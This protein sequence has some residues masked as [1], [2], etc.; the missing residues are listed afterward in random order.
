MNNCLTN[1]ARFLLLIGVIP[2][3]AA[4]RAKPSWWKNAVIY[5]VYP[6]SFQDSDGDGV[7]DLKGISSRLDYLEGLGVDAI[8]IA[9]FFSSPQVDFGYD[10]SN[11]TAVDP[12]YGS[13]ADFDALVLAARARHIR[14][15]L[16]LVLNHTSD[17]HPRFKASRSSRADSKRDWYVWKDGR[18]A[19]PPSNWPDGKGSA[20]TRDAAT[21]QYY[22]HAYAVEQPDL[23]WRSEAMR[24][25]M[26][27]VMRFWMRRGVAGFRLD[28]VPHLIEDARLR[29]EPPERD[30]NG[31]ISRDA[32]GAIRYGYTRYAFLPESHEALKNVR[33]V[34]DAFPGR[35]LL[36]EAYVNNVG[37]LRPYYG[38]GDEIQLPMAMHF[39]FND[40]GNID[41]FRKSIAGLETL[42]VG[43]EPLIVFGNHD[44]P[45]WDRF[46]KDSR[47]AFVIATMLL[48]TRGTATLYQ[49]DEIGMT[50][51][52]PQRREDVRDPVGVGGWP[53]NKGRDGSRTPMQWS[54]AIGG[55][56][57]TGKPWLPVS[58]NLAVH[59]VE[60]LTR[61]GG[62][63]L[64][65]H[66]RLIALRRTNAAL[67]NG[68][69]TIVDAANPAILAWTRHV[70]G[71]A[72]VIVATNFTDSSATLHLAPG[73]VGKARTLMSTAPTGPTIDIKHLDLAPFGVF[74]GEID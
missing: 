32:S 14:V 27:D 35:V 37:E 73:K 10:I 65:W 21:G 22:Y 45:R 42:P 49:G 52:V 71:H 54:A 67:A 16:D 68:R 63:L 58:D 41:Q 55:G 57:T 6:R 51:W 13:M 61:D 2:P 43:D 18:G 60:T 46:G 44:Q 24:S 1:F 56:F 64:N 69:T 23:N 19:A 17:Q 59:N 72:T 20:W 29:D 66:K 7:G 8:W 26:A 70:P 74:I 38:Q 31:I 39:G 30:A 3:V 36:S 25:A 50:T 33:R 40:T 34:T 48:A 53:T 11:Y 5:E 47:Q 28:T 15:I 12:M 9:P 4:L 62:S